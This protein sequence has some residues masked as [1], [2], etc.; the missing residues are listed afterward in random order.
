MGASGRGGEL[1]GML[2]VKGALQQSRRE[3]VVCCG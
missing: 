3:T 2:I 1:L